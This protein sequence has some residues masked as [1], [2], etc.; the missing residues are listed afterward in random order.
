MSRRDRLLAFAKQVGFRVRWEADAVV[1]EDVP[2]LLADGQIGSC[3]IEKSCDPT[4]GAPTEAIGGATHGARVTVTNGRGDRVFHVDGEPI[5]NLIG[6]DGESWS[7]LSIKRSGANGPEGDV[8]ASDVVHRYAKQIVGAVSAK[9]HLEG[10][11]SGQSRNR[12]RFRTPLK[13]EPV[14]D[15]CKSNSVTAHSNHRPRRHRGVF[16]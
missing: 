16:A 12:S 14:W 3:R 5:G 4:N 1:L 9:G 10:V 8:S 2:C 6:G 15:P 11:F 13:P 7:D